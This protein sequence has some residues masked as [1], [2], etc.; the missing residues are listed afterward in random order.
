MGVFRS[1]L[2]LIPSHFR[3]ALGVFLFAMKLLR[4]CL[5]DYEVGRRLEAD[6]AEHP[7]RPPVSPHKEPT[8]RSPI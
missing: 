4:L 5:P 3:G 7:A 8:R 6:F 2:N 1:Y